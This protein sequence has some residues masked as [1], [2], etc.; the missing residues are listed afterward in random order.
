MSKNVLQLCPKSAC[1]KQTQIT[2][3]VFHVSLFP[4]RFGIHEYQLNT[5][6]LAETLKTLCYIATATFNNFGDNGS[7]IVKPDFSGNPTDV[8]IYGNQTFPKTLHVF[9]VIKLE[10]A[11]VA[12]WKTE[13][14]ILCFVVKPAVF[15]KI[16][17]SKICLAFTG[18]MHKKNVAIGSL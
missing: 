3:L 2:N 15:T 5:V 1:K 8:L 12:V 14:K 7:G 4:S 13:H 10:K 16:S 18:M 9:S 17:S 11:A 6:V